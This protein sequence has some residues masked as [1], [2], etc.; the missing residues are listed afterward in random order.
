MTVVWG[1][2]LFC[3]VFVFVVVGFLGGGGVPLI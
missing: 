3:F 2:F 1:V